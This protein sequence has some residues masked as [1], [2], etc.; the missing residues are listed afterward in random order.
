MIKRFL[1][2]VAIAALFASCNNAGTNEEEN[3]ADST[4]VE[5]A[6]EEEIPVI[7]LTEFAEKAGNYVDKK[8]KVT[9]I[10]DHICKHGGKKINLVADNVDIHV[11]G[12]EKFDE[13]LT[14]N[15]IIV[16]GTVTEFRIDEAYCLKMEKDMIKEHSEG[17]ENDEHI[18]AKKAQIQHF[19]D[20]MKTTNVDHLSFY[21]LKY[22][23]HKVKE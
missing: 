12:E 13:A 3:N 8:V 5:V 7:L 23:S 9:G 22:I 11:F 21:D 15:E 10:V 2:I 20:S 4:K 1:S 6:V 18:K 14:G 17:K 16:T 19:R